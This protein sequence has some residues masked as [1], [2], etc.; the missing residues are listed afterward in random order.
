VSDNLV[1]FLNLDERSTWTNAHCLV[2]Y[3]T[4][5]R[6]QHQSVFCIRMHSR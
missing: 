5:R 4:L 6:Q 2:A 1:R 3:D